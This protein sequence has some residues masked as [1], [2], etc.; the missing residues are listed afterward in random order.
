MHIE[1]VSSFFFFLLLAAK[2]DTPSR[3]PALLGIVL[4]TKELRSNLLKNVRYIVERIRRLSRLLGSV[5]NFSYIFQMRMRV[6]AADWSPEA[7]KLVKHGE[8]V[9]GPKTVLVWL[10]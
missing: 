7:E 1:M 8:S 5:A 6:A 2:V 3:R 10:H 9:T 4:Y